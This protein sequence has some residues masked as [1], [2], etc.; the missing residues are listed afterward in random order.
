MCIGHGQSGLS[1]DWI[2]DGVKVSFFLAS[3]LGVERVIQTPNWNRR[4]W[5]LGMASCTLP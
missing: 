3:D 5:V 1:N 2:K 4:M